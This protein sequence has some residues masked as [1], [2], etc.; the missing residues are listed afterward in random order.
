MEGDPDFSEFCCSQPTKQSV[1]DPIS[2]EQ[3]LGDLSCS[4][5][6]VEHWERHMDSRGA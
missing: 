5:W 4:R 1:G 3:S 6:A 2:P